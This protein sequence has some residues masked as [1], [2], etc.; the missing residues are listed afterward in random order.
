[1]IFTLHVNFSHDS[2]TYTHNFT[3][4]KVF[5]KKVNSFTQAFVTLTPTVCSPERQANIFLLLDASGSLG[6]RNFDRTLHF[7]EGIVDSFTIGP[8][9][10]RVGLA[11]FSKY[12]DNRIWLDQ[13]MNKTSLLEAVHAI[14]YTKG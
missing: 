11:T 9:S 8:D 12:V 2:S 1:M 7:A 4:S 5:K 13:Y 3:A 6:K 10:V 14:R